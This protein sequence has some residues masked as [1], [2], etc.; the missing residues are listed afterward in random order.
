MYKRQ[1]QLL[2][3]N[4]GPD[5]CAIHAPEDGS[6]LNLQFIGEYRPHTELP[7]LWGLHGIHLKDFD[8]TGLAAVHPHLK[9]LRLWG[10]P[11]NLDVYKR[12]TWYCNP[13]DGEDASKDLLPLIDGD[14]QTYVEYGKWF[15]PADLPRCV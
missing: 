2:F 6:G 1:E 5:A 11:G 14:P 8:L 10:A 13:M 4:K 7:N 12:Q 3:Q 15:Y 9:E